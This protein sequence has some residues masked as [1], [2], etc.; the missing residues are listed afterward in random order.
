[1]AALT[2]QWWSTQKKS[3]GGSNSPKSG[4]GEKIKAYEKLEKDPKATIEAKQKAVMVVRDLLY[5]FTQGQKKETFVKFP[6]LIE[7]MKSL[8]EVAQRRIL[9][10]SQDTKREKEKDE[11]GDEAQQLLESYVKKCDELNNNYENAE[12]KLKTTTEFFRY[13][14]LIEDYIPKLIAQ[15]D[16]ILNNTKDFAIIAEYSKKLK[17]LKKRIEELTIEQKL[18]QTKENEGQRARQQ[19]LETAKSVDLGW[20][21]ALQTGTTFYD[22][23]KSAVQN[24]ALE[25]VNEWKGKFAKLIKPLLEKLNSMMG[26]LKGGKELMTMEDVKKIGL[27][28]AFATRAEKECGELNKKIAEVLKK[29]AEAQKQMKEMAEYM[30]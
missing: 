21:R 13:K 17:S 12:L 25:E 16:K 28:G 3:H 22:A 7:D 2:S 15:I 14:E 23:A 29:I 9:E 27:P 24:G 30:G 19:F 11:K 4:I 20:T 6:K 1:M 18:V 10:F 8:Y 5:T 26:G